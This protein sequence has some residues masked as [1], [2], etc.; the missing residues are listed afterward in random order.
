MVRRELGGNVVVAGE[1]IRLEVFHAV[2]D[3][4]DPLT[5]HDRGGDGDHVAGMDRHLA[6]EAAADVG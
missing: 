2:F 6:A 4:L 5:E 1:R 3:P